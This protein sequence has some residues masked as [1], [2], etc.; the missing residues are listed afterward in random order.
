MAILLL[1]GGMCA[2]LP[3]EPEQLALDRLTARVD[4]KDS[5]A[6]FDRALEPGR[7]NLILDGMFHDLKL[8]GMEVV[9]IAR[10]PLFVFEV[11][12]KAPAIA[13]AHQVDGLPR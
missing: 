7:T 13:A 6:K 1:G 2:S 5:P 12:S 9:P 10:G 3:V 11:K 4:V 8:G